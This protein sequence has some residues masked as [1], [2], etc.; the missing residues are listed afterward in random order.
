ML[1]SNHVNLKFK[2]YSVKIQNYLFAWTKIDPQCTARMVF[3]ESPILPF[4][5][6][7]IP[8]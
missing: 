4:K 6:S 1:I 2:L 7:Q 5:I 3:L 8:M